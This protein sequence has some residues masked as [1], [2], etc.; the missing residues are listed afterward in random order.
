MAEITT[1]VW[2]SGRLVEERKQEIDWEPSAADLDLV[3]VGCECG[4]KFNIPWD[5]LAFGGFNG[6]YCG[7]CGETGKMDVIAD[8]AKPEEIL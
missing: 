6:M 8:P 5:A 1:K 4:N 2:K 7:Q 3:T